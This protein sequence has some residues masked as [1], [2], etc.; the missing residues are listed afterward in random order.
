MDTSLAALASEL[1]HPIPDGLENGPKLSMLR[2]TLNEKLAIEGSVWR[3]VWIAWQAPASAHV[4]LTLNIKHLA[5]V[6]FLVQP[7]PKS[8]SLDDLRL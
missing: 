6:N 5:N 4:S 3:A 2:P 8:G 7:L 1:A